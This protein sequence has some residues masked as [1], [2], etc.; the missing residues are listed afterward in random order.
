MPSAL[1]S[2]V[3]IEKECLVFIVC[4]HLILKN[5][6]RFRML[7]NGIIELRIMYVIYVDK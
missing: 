4:C 6:V 3:E 1:R 5:P 2:F 7:S